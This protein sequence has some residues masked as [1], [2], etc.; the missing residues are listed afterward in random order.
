[1]GE[2]WKGW[3]YLHLVSILLFCLLM[4]LA[5]QATAADP[6]LSATPAAEELAG[7]VQLSP[8]IIDGVTLFSV[9]GFPAYP[10]E[11][12]AQDITGRIV[13]LAAD[14]SFNRKSLRIQHEPAVSL[15]MAGDRRIMGVIE[16]DAR[17]ERIDRQTLAMGYLFGIGESIDAWRRNRDPG[18]LQ[19]HAFYAIGATLLLVCA[20]LVWIRLYRHLHKILE[21]RFK[22]KVSDVHIQR[23]QIVRSEQLWRLLTVALNL[24]WAAVVLATVYLYLYNVLA[25]FPWT[26]GL[27]SNLLALLLDPLQTMGTAL[28][29]AVPNL[30]FLVV[31]FFITR[32]LLKIV[33]LFF[34]SVADGTVVLPEFEAEWAWPTFRLVR[35]MLVAFAIIVAYP[36]IPG[37]ETGAFKGVS[38][39][40]GLVFSLG[41]SSLIGNLIAGYSMTYRRT[42]RLGDRVKIGEHLGDV[43]YMRLLVTHLRT[44][45]NEEVIIPNSVIL[46]GEVVN[47]STLAGKQG[48]ILHTTVGIGYETPWRQVE[49]MLLEAAG[50]TPGLLREPTPFVLQRAL[51]DFC[52]TYEINAYCTEAQAMA[53]LYTEL[54]RN[55]LD[56]F[57]EYGVQIMTPAYEGDPAEPKVVAKED[58]YAPPARPPA[59]NTTA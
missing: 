33:R 6:P 55:I 29:K 34:A 5:Q 38:L 1:M 42:F 36:Y 23:F 52:V 25:L 58:W 37:S 51:G 35:L 49:A 17:L 15:I 46:G 16:G 50:R 19:R 40:I 11:K 31:L 56:L 12:R 20:L 53:R 18:L 9:R 3:P 21:T 24:L 59:G 10:A 57:N 44:P 14:Q 2:Q 22:L 4:G 43:E 26:R 8:V 7:E 28:L 39:F 45:K 27:A 41:S 32:Y 30:A 13:A 47:F 48:L 54:H